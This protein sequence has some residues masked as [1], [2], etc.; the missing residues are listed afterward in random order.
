MGGKLGILT[1]ELDPNGGLNPDIMNEQLE[2]IV[3]PA[4]ML[5]KVIGVPLYGGWQVET[6]LDP[7]VQPFL[8]DH[9]MD[10][11]PLL[12][13][14]M[15]TEAFA[16]LAALVAPGYRVLAVEQEQFDSPFKFY[17]ME[18]QTLLLSAT[19]Q[20]VDAETILAQV[21]LRS[22]RT[23][24]TGETQTRTHFRAKIRLGKDVPEFPS[25]EFKPL[26]DGLPIMAADIYKV[27]FHGPAYHVLERATVSGDC[28]IGL[29]AEG[30]P[31]NTH[32]AESMSL[33]SPRLIE[34][35]FQTAG[36]WEMKTKGA[37]AL[38]L[39]IASVIAYRDPADAE[40]QRLYAIAQPI[41]D[42]KHFDVDVVDEQGRVYVRLTGYRTVRLRNPVK[43]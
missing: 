41:D 27:Y 17:R 12:P 11:T 16:Q 32:P 26:T 6:T 18:A 30:L 34:L 25:I 43:L 8:Y 20:L 40:G 19:P 38:P 13:G 1:Q 23:L 5:G 33:M 31:P 22:A 28:A 4:V 39:S 3:P 9:A 7:T 21:Q 29:M 2:R 36:I 14:V 35:A 37:L 15:G 10:G 24:A 42:G